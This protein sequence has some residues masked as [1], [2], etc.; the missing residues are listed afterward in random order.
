MPKQPA[1]S[2]LRDSM[3]TKVTRWEQFLAEMEAVVPSVRVRPCGG[4]LPCMVARPGAPGRVHGAEP[5]EVTSTAS[6]MHSVRAAVS[7][8]RSPK[9]VGGAASSSNDARVSRACV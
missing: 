6:S 8:S 3:K 1:V 2:G 5:V 7:A 9:P 4:G